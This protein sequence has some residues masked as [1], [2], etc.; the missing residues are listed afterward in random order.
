MVSFL[1]VWRGLYSVHL[2]VPND[3]GTKFATFRI[4][5]GVRDVPDDLDD[6]FG[7]A[8]DRNPVG[9]HLSTDHT[10]GEV[11]YH[12]TCAVHS[13]SWISSVICSRNL[14]RERRVS[15]IAWNPSFK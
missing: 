13:R 1:S 6:R 8:C 4:E 2:D 12:T 10:S 7:V 3:K 9:N 5:S 11:K 14:T 15:K